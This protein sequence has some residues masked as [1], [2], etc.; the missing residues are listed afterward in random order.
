MK[1]R[2][3]DELIEELS[4]YQSWDLD[5]P[6]S[7]TIGNNGKIVVALGKNLDDI[8]TLIEVLN[9]AEYHLEEALDSLDGDN[10]N[11]CDIENAL[12]CVENAREIAESL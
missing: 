6:I 3:I 9:Q 8:S 5:S 11:C 2:T 4:K 12:G 7:V 1:C 10:D